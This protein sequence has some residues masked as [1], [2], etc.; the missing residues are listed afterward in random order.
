MPDLSNLMIGP[1]SALPIHRSCDAT[2]ASSSSSP[3]E[4]LEG[5]PDPKPD[6]RLRLRISNRGT[7]AA[8]KKERV[9]A[10]GKGRTLED[11]VRAWVER[12]MAGGVEERECELPFLTGA[13]KLV[14]WV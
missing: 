3:V 13:S 14:S 7:C 4:T 12:K 8:V 6:R 9:N 1:L 5:D 2:I 11:H 10:E